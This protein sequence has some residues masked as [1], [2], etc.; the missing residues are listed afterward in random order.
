MDVAHP[1][2]RR[3]GCTAGLSSAAGAADPSG[4]VP[5]GHRCLHRGRGR[6]SMRMAR[7]RLSTIPDLDTAVL[8][9]EQL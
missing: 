7:Y 2:S 9:R 3:S 5:V 1:S 4:A 8:R 6:P